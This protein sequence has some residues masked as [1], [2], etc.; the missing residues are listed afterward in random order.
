MSESLTIVRIVNASRERVFAAWT[1]PDA[2]AH[3]FMAGEDW[4]CE[5]TADVRVGGE[6]T[7]T[8]RDPSGAVHEQFGRYREI[9]PPSRL[10]FTWSFVP[11]GVSDSVVTIELRALAADRTELTLTHEL[12]PTSDVRHSHEQGW[13]GC[14]AN[15]DRT[16]ERNPSWP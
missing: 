8:M 4:T 6:Y 7:L 2:I 12:L 14:L 13:A 3:W 1:R 11:L 5:P 16:L 9:E 10:V 15:L